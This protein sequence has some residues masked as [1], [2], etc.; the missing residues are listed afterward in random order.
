MS[1][2]LLVM[3][4]FVLLAI[5]SSLYFVGC[6]LNT[7]GEGVD[8]PP[9]PPPVL[10]YSDDTVLADSD[11]LLAYWRLNEASGP[12]AEN[13]AKPGTAN[14]KYLSQVFAADPVASSA[15]APFA[16]LLFGQAGL[17]SGD[18]QSPFTAGSMRQPCISVDGG[19]VS[20]DWDPVIAPSEADGFTIE[21]WVHVGW[22]NKDLDFDRA[23]VGALESTGGYKGFGILA[24]KNHTWQAF[25]GNGTD[26][27]FL[28]GA[29]I[30]LDKTYH[31]VATYTP[32]A[33][34]PGTLTLYVN[35]SSSA[36]SATYVPTTGTGAPGIASRLFIGAG[37]TTSVD[38][39]IPFVGRIQCVALYRGAFSDADVQTHL[40]AGNA[41]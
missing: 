29:A 5:V 10:K 8:N 7:Q 21:A 41:T 35:G 40:K 6:V 27:T 14:G 4:P 37:G 36:M 3:T 13:A 32:G 39:K 22:G 31:L 9:V 26:V 24:S 20:V 16:T 28:P 2:S 11:R 17:L 12:T 19:Y 18:L 23:V 25:V 33:G 38:P 1:T 15:A 30:D 34:A